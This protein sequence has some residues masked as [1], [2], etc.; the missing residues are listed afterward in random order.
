MSLRSAGAGRAHFE[1]LYAGR[2]DPW[3]YAGSAYERDKYAASLAALPRRRFRSALELGCSIGIFT[4][5]L[6]PRCRALLAVDIAPAALLRARARCPLRHVRFRAAGVPRWRPAGRFELIV[7]SEVLYYLT[8]AELAR[9]AARAPGML[10]PGGVALLVNYLGGT[11]APLSG[12]RAARGFIAGS[13]LR[14]V[15]RRRTARYRLDL[16]RAAGPAGGR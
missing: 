7:L 13:G 3:D 16:L 12:E 1:L 5:L 11:D 14:V 9:F 8:A 6:A 2:H 10:A 4:G 15:R